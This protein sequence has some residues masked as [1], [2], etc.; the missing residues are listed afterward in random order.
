MN[1]VGGMYV[2]EE[3]HDM[4][5]DTGCSSTRKYYCIIDKLDS[6]ISENEGGAS[7]WALINECFEASKRPG[8]FLFRDSIID[9]F[10]VFCEIHF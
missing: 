1:F 3:E 10:L 2:S 7:V 6:Q 9:S 5:G 4:I 8:F